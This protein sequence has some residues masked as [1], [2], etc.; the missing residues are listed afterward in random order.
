[1]RAR[2]RTSLDTTRHSVRKRGAGGIT[3]YRNPII[4]GERR[5]STVNGLKSDFHVMSA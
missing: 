3:G 4:R 5:Q 1:M 2:S